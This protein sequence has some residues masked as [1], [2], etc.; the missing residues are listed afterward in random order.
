MV[1]LSFPN[2]AVSDGASDFDRTADFMELNAFYARTEPVFTS[3]LANEAAIGAAE[4]HEDLDAELSSGEEDIV[5]GTVNRMEM[6]KRVLEGAYPFRLDARGEV[7]T[8]ELM[9]ESLGQVA[10]VLSLVLSNLRPMS[11]ILN[12]SPLHPTGTEERA[13][14]KD[15]EYFATAAL[16]AEIQGDAWAFGFPRQDQTSFLRKLT[17]IWEKFGDGRVERQ[18]GAPRHA[19]DD[20]VDVFAARRHPDGL[21]G[22]LLAAAQ[23]ATGKNRSGKSLKGWRDSFYR[24]WF[25]KSPIT[26]FVPY[27]IVPFAMDRATLTDEVG[28]HGNVLHRLRMPR[29]VAE[30]ARLEKS[31]ILVEG[32]DLL[33]AASQR[34][35]D[36]RT[37][38]EDES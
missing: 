2:D 16:A 38:A 11:P 30:A 24:R 5:S 36:Y 13:M 25:S 28:Q 19:K 31:G 10:Y 8:C 4:D 20:R 37:R 35:R 9:E 1:R 26:E 21:P 12:G 14:R 18:A 32:Y 33:P 29:R 22:F 15:F 17:E 3:V 34:V 7:V 6:R 23:V 27:L